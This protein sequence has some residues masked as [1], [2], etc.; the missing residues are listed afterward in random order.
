MPTSYDDMSMEELEV[1]NQKLDEQKQAIRKQQLEVNAAMTRR[2][3]RDKL[4]AMS[5]EEKSAL[6]Q[7]I[8]AD[9]IPSE[10]T[11]QGV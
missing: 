6:A 10:E 7:V 1:E 3:A 4:A 9:G 5:D 2:V 11:V 8:Q